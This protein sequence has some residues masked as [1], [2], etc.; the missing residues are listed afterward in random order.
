MHYQKIAQVCFHITTATFP[1]IGYSDTSTGLSVFSWDS[2]TLSFPP[3]NTEVSLDQETLSFGTNCMVNFSGYY[4]SQCVH[5]VKVSTATNGYLLRQS[6]DD[7]DAINNP[8]SAFGNPRYIEASQ[9]ETFTPVSFIFDPVF[10]ATATVRDGWTMEKIDQVQITFIGKGPANNDVVDSYPWAASYAPNWTTDAE[11]NFPS[12]TILYLNDYDL[13]LNKSGYESYTWE[14]II[15]NGLPGDA[16]NLETLFIY[17]SDANNN[18]IADSWEINYFGNSCSAHT[19]ADADGMS[20]YNEYIAG[21][22]PTDF[23]SCLW[24]QQTQTESGLELIWDTTPGRTYCISGTTNLCSSNSWKQVAGPWECFDDPKEM[25]WTETHQNLSWGN[26]Y[27][28]DV[29]P[30][31]HTATNSILINTNTPPNFN[32][33]GGTNAWD[34][35]IPPF[36]QT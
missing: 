22:D 17:P 7:P 2:Y 3:P 18:L 28:V 13:H 16:F 5:T 30:C 31:W 33:G 26:Y 1:L 15:T 10:T 27:R 35:G 36:P 14:N 34:G 25:N 23:Y 8:N 12:N 32:G 24:V 19:D 20:N 9:D 4:D 21:T 29:V 6:P 11:G